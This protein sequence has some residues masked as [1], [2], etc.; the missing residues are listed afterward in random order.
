MK[1]EAISPRRG[2]TQ[3]IRQIQVIDRSDS[4][5]QSLSLRRGSMRIFGGIRR[6]P[7]PFPAD[8]WACGA[9]GYVEPYLREPTQ[10][11]AAH[12]ESM[13]PP[14]VMPGAIGQTGQRPGD[15]CRTRTIIALVLAGVLALRFP[16]LVA[17]LLMR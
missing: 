15:P 10:L 8:A 2:S 17:F 5:D 14:A 4:G 3:I 9:C 6:I 16:A 11:L 13:R 7:R 1:S 12:E